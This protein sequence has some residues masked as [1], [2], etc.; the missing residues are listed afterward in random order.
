MN[1]A[2]VVAQAEDAMR[3]LATQ[4]GAVLGDIPRIG[5][6]VLS[7]APP[8]GE[9]PRRWSAS[10]KFR[11]G[12]VDT[13]YIV[14][15]EA[16]VGRVVESELVYYVVIMLA[17]LVEMGVLGEYPDNVEVVRFD[18]V[19]GDV[20]PSKRYPVMHRVAEAIGFTVEYDDEPGGRR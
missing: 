13:P 15:G 20:P 7:S 11:Q 6:L 12:N 10:I 8:D 3:E 17:R 9:H 1:T 14:I 5:A 4:H 19:L 18:P 2:H 16:N